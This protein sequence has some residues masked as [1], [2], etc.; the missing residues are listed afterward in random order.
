MKERDYIDVLDTDLTVSLDDAEC[1]TCTRC[2]A[3]VNL[4]TNEVECIIDDPLDCEYYQHSTDY[5]GEG[6]PSELNFEV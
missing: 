5:D 6:E 2:G 3:R 1:I 4:T